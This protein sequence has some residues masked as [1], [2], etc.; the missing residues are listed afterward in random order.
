MVPHPDLFSKD[1]FD[2][3]EAIYLENFAA[4]SHQIHRDTP[5]AWL[6]VLT[7]LKK[8]S[9][10][11]GLSHILWKIKNVWN[12]QPVIVKD[13]AGNATEDT[14]HWCGRDQQNLAQ[15]KSKNRGKNTPF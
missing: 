12:H 9:Q 3:D 1:V 4:V 10:W 13:S 11:E 5:S 2:I 8:I 6:V 7:I 14:E 15:N